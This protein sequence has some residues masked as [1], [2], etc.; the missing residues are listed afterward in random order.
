MHYDWSPEDLD[1]AVRATQHLAL[2]VIRILMQFS[3]VLMIGLSVSFV[4][5]L[6]PVSC[7]S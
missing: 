3:I 1:V 2:H 5:I 7:Y 6:W 4:H